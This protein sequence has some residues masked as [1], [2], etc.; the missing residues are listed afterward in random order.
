MPPKT[1]CNCPEINDQDWHM[2]DQTWNGKFFYFEYVRHIFS[3]PMGFDVQVKKMKQDLAHKGYQL[4]IPDLVLHQ[5]GMFQGRILVEIQDPE[6]YDANVEPLDNARIL[7]R[8]V[9]GSGAR[10]G[11]ALQEL[12]TFTRDRTHL[13]PTVVY[14]WHTTCKRCAKTRGYEKTVLFARV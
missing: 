2:K 11:Q 8:V 13:D 9:K 3:F 7:S 10:M 5:P 6:Q 1:A 14:Y 12:K 4:V